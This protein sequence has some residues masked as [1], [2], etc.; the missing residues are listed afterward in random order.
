M[1]NFLKIFLRSLGTYLGYQGGLSQPLV[2][3]GFNRLVILVTY[4]MKYVTVEAVFV[5][6]ILAMKL[7]SVH[8]CF[9]IFY[10]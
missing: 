5:V 10:C 8:M 4:G 6:C 7:T 9:V 3:V 1:R 2:I